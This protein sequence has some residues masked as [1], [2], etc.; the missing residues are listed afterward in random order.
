MFSFTA[1]LHCGERYSAAVGEC[2]IRGAG[3]DPRLNPA[4]EVKQKAARGSPGPEGAAAR[5]AADSTARPRPARPQ[6]LFHGVLD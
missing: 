6:V 3:P 2:S 5:N 1:P 4:D